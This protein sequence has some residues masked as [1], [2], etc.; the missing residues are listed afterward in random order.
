M[1]QP[2]AAVA[3]TAFL[4]NPAFGPSSLLDPLWSLLSSFWSAPESVD[5]GCGMD[6]YGRCIPE[7]K[8]Q[9]DEGIGWDPYGRDTPGAQGQSDAGG[10]D[11][12][13]RDIPGAQGQSDIGI[14]MD[15]D[16]SNP[17]PR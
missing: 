7:T 13:G 15:P 14:G 10:W 12:Y 11:P 8:G 1:R 2:L 3:L 17:T 6:P 5:E 9:S 4:L 16:G